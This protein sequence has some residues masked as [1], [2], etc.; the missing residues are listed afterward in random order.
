[1]AG[2]IGEVAL[3]AVEVFWYPGGREGYWPKCR[4]GGRPAV[5]YKGKT[6]KIHSNDNAAVNVLI[7]SSKQMKRSNKSITYL[8]KLSDHILLV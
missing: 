3:W 5:K 6:L 1:M 7:S 2:C 8:F 4:P